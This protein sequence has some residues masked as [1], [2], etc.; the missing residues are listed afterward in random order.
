MSQEYNLTDF[1]KSVSHNKNELILDADQPEYVEKQ[2]PP[3]VINKMLAK[4][5]DAILHVNEMNISHHLPNDAQYRYYLNILRARNRYK[6]KQPKDSS[7]ENDLKLIQRYYS[8]NRTVAHLHLRALT[9]EQLSFIKSKT[10]T[11][12]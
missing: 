5:P 12:G 2:Y 10:N 1:I 8:C 11:G 7:N 3:Y 6:A 9:K 4:Y